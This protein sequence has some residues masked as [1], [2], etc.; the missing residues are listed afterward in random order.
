MNLIRLALG[1]IQR[2]SVAEDIELREL[3]EEMVT[4]GT[5]ADMLAT[6]GRRGRIAH[7]ERQR[8]EYEEDNFIRL[9]L[10][11]KDKKRRKVLSATSESNHLG[12][13]NEFQRLSVLADR[14]L[15]MGAE[16]WHSSW[17]K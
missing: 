10:T 15:D 13:G 12:D 11:N 14:V 7:E 1:W 6:S 3:P 9:T 17:A 16:K 2:E 4:D 8:V 5:K